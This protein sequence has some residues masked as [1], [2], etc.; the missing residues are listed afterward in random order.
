[1]TLKSTRR[2]VWILGVC[3]CAQLSSGPT[4]ATSCWRPTPAEHVDYAGMIFYGQVV[5]GYA[6]PADDRE[7]SVEFRVL[8]AYKGVRSSTVRIEYLNDHG[9]LKGWGFEYGQSIL[10]FADRLSDAGSGRV[11]Y[12]SM[13]PYHGRPELHAEYWDVLV[14]LDR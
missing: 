2:L 3:L 9:G 11:D 6:G 12:C 4:G 10:V 7:R 14:T 13:I 8:R 1:M 5:G